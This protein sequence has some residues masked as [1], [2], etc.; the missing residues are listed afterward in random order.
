MKLSFTPAAWD[1][2]L[3][4]QDHDRKLVK[5]INLLIKDILTRPEFS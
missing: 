4:F 2:Y 3:W 1:D 5:R